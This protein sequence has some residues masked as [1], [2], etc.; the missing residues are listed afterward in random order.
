MP[1]GLGRAGFRYQSAGGAAPATR[2][3][4]TM[5][6][7]GVTFSTT[8]KQFGTYGAF[9]DGADK[10]STPNNADFYLGNNAYTIEFWFNTADT[11]SEIVNQQDYGDNRGWSVGTRSSQRMLFAA[12]SDSEISVLVPA[13]GGW[14]DNTWAHVAVCHTAG[15]GV[16][17]FA[18]GVRKYYNSGW[19]VD[20]FDTIDDFFIGTGYGVSSGLFSDPGDGGTRGGYFYNGYIDELRISTVDRYGTANS[21]ITVPTAAFTNDADTVLL[22][23]FENNV[24]D[25]GGA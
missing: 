21:T 5:T 11:V 23:H 16:A 12:G 19:N 24:D 14:T 25:D 18:N 15:G 3:P 13:T 6:N 1:L 4:K 7:S 17:I 8:E 2:T 20:I 10:I 22:M 9:F